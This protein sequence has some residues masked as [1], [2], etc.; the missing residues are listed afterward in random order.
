LQAL[1]EWLAPFL[2]FEG[3]FEAL[4]E[5]VEAAHFLAPD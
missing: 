4:Y 1:D 5:I 2:A 3:G